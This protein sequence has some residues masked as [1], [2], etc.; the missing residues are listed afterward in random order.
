MRARGLCSRCDLSGVGDEASEALVYHAMNVGSVGSEVKRDERGTPHLERLGEA[1]AGP[2]VSH[3]TIESV[4]RGETVVA[5]DFN[6]AA[7]ERL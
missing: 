4:R 2:F 1:D 6:H 3:V 5:A 7:A